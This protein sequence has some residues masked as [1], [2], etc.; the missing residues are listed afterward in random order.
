ML[1]LGCLRNL[2]K[3][4]TKRKKKDH[5]LHTTTRGRISLCRRDAPP[6]PT[7]YRYYYLSIIFRGS[8]PTKFCVEFSDLAFREARLSSARHHFQENPTR[9]ARRF[10]V[11]SLEDREW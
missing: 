6:F 8:F 3:N 11:C 2:K 9:L 7:S 1:R 5:T 4:K 10:F